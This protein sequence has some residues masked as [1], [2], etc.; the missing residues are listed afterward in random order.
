MTY[1][2]ASIVFAAILVAFIQTVRIYRRPGHPAWLDG[3][4]MAAT[5]CIAFTAGISLALG[6]VV[7]SATSLPLPVWG[8]ALAAVAAIVLAVAL[9]IIL[10]R[11][12]G[13]PREVPRP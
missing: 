3:D 1:M 4:G 5:V 6:F 11:R 8:D 10:A 2:F 13:A 9:A 12:L 7:Q